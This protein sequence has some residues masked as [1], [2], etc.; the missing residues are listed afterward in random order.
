MEPNA[1]C[2]CHETAFAIH[3][4]PLLRGFCHCSICQEFNEAPYGDIT[5]FRARDVDLPDEQKVNYKYYTSPPMV[6]R[7][8]CAACGKPAVETLSL[9]LMPELVIVP[10]ANVHESGLVP[11]PAM[12]IFYGSRQA[13]VQDELP[14]YQGYLRSQLAFSMK[15]IKALFRK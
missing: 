11:E 9:P 5:I 4:K 14:K 8:K 12:H 6:R 2:Q 13:D 10:S 7:G 15:L 1:S 3:G